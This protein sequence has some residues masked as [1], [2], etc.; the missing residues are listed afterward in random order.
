MITRKDVEHIAK[1]ARLHL[2]K[3][4]EENL[5]NELASILEFVEKLKEVDV[6][7][8]GPMTGGTMLRDITR[9]DEILNKTLEGKPEEL[10]SQ[11]PERTQAWVR[12]KAVFE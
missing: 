7:G 2:T 11:A 5:G 6:S 8:V 9:P 4:E 1:L 12:V 3:T 10:L